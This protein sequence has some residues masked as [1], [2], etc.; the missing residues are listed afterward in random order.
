MRYW[1]LVAKNTGLA[2]CRYRICAIFTPM[3]TLIAWPYM[4]DTAYLQER[5]ETNTIVS[6]KVSD[7]NVM[8]YYLKFH[9]SFIRT[10]TLLYI[11]YT[12]TIHSK[13]KPSFTLPLH[14]QMPRQSARSS[15][16]RLPWF[17]YKIQWRIQGG[18]GGGGG[19]PG[20]PSNS[21]M[22]IINV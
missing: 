21:S 9:L 16:V 14:H 7:I 6:L 5:T 12:Y 4:P 1:L 3:R 10:N 8:I 17:L 20:S 18:G 2:H 13:R 15:L 19:G 11:I 22:N